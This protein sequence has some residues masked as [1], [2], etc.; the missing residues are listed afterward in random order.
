MSG[1]VVFSTSSPALF[2]TSQWIIFSSI[3]LDFT[4][5]VFRLHVC[6]VLTGSCA[7]TCSAASR[8]APATFCFPSGSGVTGGAA[9]GP[10]SLARASRGSSAPAGPSTAS[11]RSSSACSPTRPSSCSASSRPRGGSSGCSTWVTTSR[12]FGARATASGTRRTLEG[13]RWGSSTTR[14][15]GAAASSD[16]RSARLGGR[17]SR[18]SPGAGAVLRRWRTAGLCEMHGALPSRRPALFPA[19]LLPPRSGQYLRKKCRER[20]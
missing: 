4:A 12:G 5:S 20:G 13:R 15:C 19:L 16:A 6:W 3:C 18:G 11:P 14:R 9:T 1:R 8:A 7:T 10:S 2:R 17:R